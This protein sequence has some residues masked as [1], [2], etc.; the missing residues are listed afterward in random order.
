MTQGISIN[1]VSVMDTVADVSFATAS[2]PPEGAIHLK[3]P[4]N[5]RFSLNLIGADGSDTF[6]KVDTLQNLLASKLVG[7]GKVRLVSMAINYI[8]KTD[9]SE[10]YVG[11]YNAA[12]SLTMREAATQKGGVLVLPNSFVKGI[13]H[14]RELVVP[15]EYSSQI[16]PVSSELPAW[17]LYIK[18]VEMIV[19]LH[20]DIW[21][22]GA[23]IDICTLKC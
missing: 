20:I 17:N 18:A 10:L 14:E 22:D 16:Q 2:A 12:G 5:Y 8:G 6:S 13:Q 19:T 11:I 1:C 23:I 3:R 4:Y 9:T 15:G 21:F 7:M